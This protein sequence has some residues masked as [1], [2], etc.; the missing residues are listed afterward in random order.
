MSYLCDVGLALKKNDYDKLLAGAEELD[1]N[2]PQQC[3]TNLGIE[4]F[5]KQGYRMTAKAN[6]EPVVILFWPNV[7]WYDPFADVQYITSFLFKIPNSD[8]EFISVGKTLGDV[9]HKNNGWDFFEAVHS[10]KVFGEVC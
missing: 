3:S 1:R 9:C 7:K 4:N 5:I 2:G 10:V 6:G 8:F